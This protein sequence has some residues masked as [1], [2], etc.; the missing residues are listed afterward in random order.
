M[1]ADQALHSFWATVGDRAEAA[2]ANRVFVMNKILTLISS[3]LLQFV[4][5][6]IIALL[7]IVGTAVLFARDKVIYQ[8]FFGRF[9][10]VAVMVVVAILGF[11]LLTLF[12]ARGW[13]VIFQAQNW[14]GWLSA[15]ALGA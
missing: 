5:Y 14:R 12:L 7:V 4:V 10:P 15:A 3:E 9:H 6:G 8:P 2:T 1:F 11:V 13:F